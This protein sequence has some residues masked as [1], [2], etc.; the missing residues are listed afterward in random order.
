MATFGMEEEYAILDP[1]TLAP[2]DEA[3]AVYRALRVERGES[4]NIQREFLLSQLERPTPV[5]ETAEAA[6][7]D[8]IGFRR[9][10]RDAA[11]SVGVIA[12]STGTYPLVANPIVLTDKSRYHRVLDE[13]RH[14]AKEYFY[15]GLHVHVGIDDRESGVRA[16]NALRVWM[17]VI[18]A[19]A[20]NSP[21]WKGED[22][23]F[24]SYRIIQLQRWA[25][26]GTPPAF[27]DA[28]DYDRRSAR[29]VGVGG[30]FDDALIAWN[31]RLSRKFPTIEVRV[32]DAQL[33]AW[34]SVLVALLI[35]ALVSTALAEEKPA[36][37]LHPELIDSALWL[38]ARDGISHRLVHPFT[39]ELEVSRTVVDALLQHTAAALAAEGDAERVTEWIDRLFAEGTGADRQRAAYS[40]G[41]LPAL[42]ALMRGALA[43]E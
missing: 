20:T 31:I 5:C 33:E 2:R 26:R 36:D 27:V 15:G 30:T 4:R 1:M 37:P 6:L 43:P 14:V 28:D 13:Y 7:A 40:A 39:G 3:P 9:R 8:L 35:R 21:L 11:T 24:S 34:H 18:A 42:A 12:A 10:L 19:L 32:G 17:P 29:I 22:T 23:G 25:T 38:A 41:G 16:M